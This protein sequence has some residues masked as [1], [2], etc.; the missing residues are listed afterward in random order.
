MSSSSS[1]RLAAMDWKATKRPSAD[2]D[3]SSELPSALPVVPVGRETSV[4][5]FAWV[6]RTKM[7]A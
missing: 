4:V 2:I 7:L 1:L 5:V 3:G 6:S